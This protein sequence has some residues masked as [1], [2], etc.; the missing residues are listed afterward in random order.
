MKS[1]FQK[2][3]SIIISLSLAFTLIFNVAA[4]SSIYIT[5]HTIVD[6]MTYNSATI[7]AYYNVHS[8][9]SNYDSD[10]SSLGGDN[11]G[12]CCAGLVKQF[13]KKVYNVTVSNLLSTT[14]IPNP[15]AGSFAQTSSPAVGDIARLN[16]STHWAIVKAVDLSGNV[17]LIEQNAW[18][19]WGFTQARF[20][21]VVSSGDTAWS[22]FRYS[23]AAGLPTYPGA[24]TLTAASSTKSTDAVTFSW[25]ATSDTSNYDL[26]ILQDGSVIKTIW[27][28]TGTSYS[29]QL[30]R[31]TILPTCSVNT[32]YTDCWTKGNTVTFTV[33]PPAPTLNGCIFNEIDRGCDI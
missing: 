27:S 9:I 26:R 19:D 16:T 23:G 3:F 28:I 25:N 31:E 20:N 14:S 8:S 29:I 4:Q 18:A 1:I 12:Y 6:S 11:F 22:F 13:Y 33:T 21:K 32:N 30:R 5:G 24:P 2:I 10:I 17:T 7:N 15:S